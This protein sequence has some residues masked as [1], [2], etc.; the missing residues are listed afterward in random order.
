MQRKC[1]IVAVESPEW[2]ARL[3]ES[4]TRCPGVLG[5]ILGSVWEVSASI[6]DDMIGYAA[7]RVTSDERAIVSAPGE[8]PR[9]L[10]LESCFA[11]DLSLFQTECTRRNAPQSQRKPLFGG[12]GDGGLHI[13]FGE[14]SL[15][16]RSVGTGN[17]V[18]RPAPPRMRLWGRWD[19][20]AGDRPRWRVRCVCLHGATTG[21]RPSCPGVHPNPRVAGWIPYGRCD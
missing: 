15:T 12:G 13:I 7:S 3:R 17:L 19:L 11:G 8:P 20:G 10:V 18:K 9:Y 5:F 2:T 14:K 6:D 16:P 1:G 4:Q 21:V